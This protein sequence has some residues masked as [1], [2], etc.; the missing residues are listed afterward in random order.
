M[1]RAT[2]A[3][4]VVSATADQDR[5]AHRR[6]PEAEVIVLADGAG[7]MVGGREAAER[8]V[9]HEFGSLR[10]PS[11][12]V[13]ALRLLDREMQADH[14]CGEST[15]VLV[16]LRGDTLFGASVGDS[17]AWALTTDAI[18]DLTRGQNRK[19]LM[20]SGEAE[21]I[22]FG[23]S[24]FADRL[25][26]ASDGLLKY[27]PR[28]RIRRAASVFVPD[29]DVAADELVAAARLPGGGLQDDLALIIVDP[30]YLPARQA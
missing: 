12:C 10:E 20:G 3:I 14:A 13:S 4:R 21:P 24:F 7:G 18:F 19:P 15:V 26:V 1:P 28:A 6:F 23:P 25:L 8:I 11:D 29:I 2:V 9:R 17:G 16:V 22:A 30:E 27:A 5:V